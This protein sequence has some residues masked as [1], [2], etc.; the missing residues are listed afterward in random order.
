MEIRI[1]F[2]SVA[3]VLSCNQHELAPERPE[4]VPESAVWAG[5]S[6]GGAWIDCQ[7]LT[8]AGS[9]DCAIYSDFSGAALQKGEYRAP[10]GV[11][12]E[13]DFNFFDGTVI[14]LKNGVL[15]SPAFDPWPEDSGLAL[16]A[17]REGQ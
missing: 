2:V 9:Y 13:L 3:F 6:D 11:A 12:V 1:L 14:G 16:R 8:E 4:N 17:T 10:A 7:A 5:G 15:L